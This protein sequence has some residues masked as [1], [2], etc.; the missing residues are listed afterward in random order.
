MPK[1]I[2]QKFLTEQVKKYLTEKSN[3]LDKFDFSEKVI[4]APSKIIKVSFLTRFCLIYLRLK[5]YSCQYS[6]TIENK[7]R[8]TKKILKNKGRTIKKSK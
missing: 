2:D 3:L 4:Y 7:A 1:K 5:G 8:T 6:F